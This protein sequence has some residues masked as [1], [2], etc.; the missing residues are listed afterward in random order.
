M[1]LSLRYYAKPRASAV[2]A[3]PYADLV[4]SLG[5][6]SYWALQSGSPAPDT[7]GAHDLTLAGSPSYGTGPGGEL[8]SALTLV[9]ASN[10]WGSVNHA[11]LRP[12]TALTVVGWLKV[13]THTNGTGVWCCG[14]TGFY[15]Y[16][17]R[18]TTTYNG[19]TAA[20][21][22]GV[23]VVVSTVGQTA[24]GTAWT[25]VAQTYDKVNQRLYLDASEDPG[26]PDA[27][28]FDIV[29][30]ANT[31]YVGTIDGSTTSDLDGLMAGVAVF[32]TALS[33]ANITSLYGAL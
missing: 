21:K 30:N 31:F 5:A 33:A 17:A 10:Q 23:S 15:G 28:T 2:S 13:T 1:A 12:T 3:T 14:T 4:A 16:Q 11:D 26:G 32:P 6:V 20:V 27:G 8:A 7:I 18:L 29:Y 25:F 24:P 19:I 9:A 22:D